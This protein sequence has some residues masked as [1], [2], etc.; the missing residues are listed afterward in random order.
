MRSRS[1]ENGC[2]K[3]MCKKIRELKGLSTNDLLLKVGQTDVIPVDVAQM[4]YDLHIHIKPVDFASLE[5]DASFKD[6]VSAKGNIL[7]I[8]M[9]EGDELAILYRESDTKNRKRF[10]L[11]HELAHCCLHMLPNENLHV[12]FRRDEASS[13][14]KEIEANTFAGE[15]L[16]PEKALKEIIRDASEIKSILIPML[17]SLFVV[18]ENVMKERCKKLN[19]QIV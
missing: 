9:A 2:E 14:P 15:L 17:S 8:V 11:A 1:S 10:T 3:N 7:G 13:D 19:I 16:I 18:S 5:N 12:E 4:C 6:A